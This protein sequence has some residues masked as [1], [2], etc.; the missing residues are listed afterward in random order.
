[1][2]RLLWKW[3]FP[4]CN[5]PITTPHAPFYPLF[6]L[7]V[8]TFYPFDFNLPF[9]FHL[10]SFFFRA[11][12]SF[13]YSP[14]YIF[15]QNDSRWSY[16][17][18]GGGGGNIYTPDYD[19]SHFNES[20]HEHLLKKSSLCLATGLPN[21]IGVMRFPDSSRYEGEFMQ[22]RVSSSC[23]KSKHDWW[24]SSI[25][26]DLGI[27]Q[28]LRKK[29]KMLFSWKFTELHIVMHAGG[30]WSPLYLPFLVSGHWSHI[31][32]NTKR[33]CRRLSVWPDFSFRFPL[34]TCMFTKKQGSI[35]WSK[36]IFI[37]PSP[38]PKMIFFPLSDTTFFKLPLWPFCLNSPYFA[39]ILP[40]SFTFLF[41]YPFLL[42]F[43]LSSFFFCIFP[44]FLF[45]FSYFSPQVTS[46]DI[47]PE[48]KRYFQH[49]DPCQEVYILY[50]IGTHPFLWNSWSCVRHTLTHTLLPGLVW[51]GMTTSKCWSDRYPP[52]VP[53]FMWGAGS[54]PGTS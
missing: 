19:R 54:G 8:S 30:Q 4:S 20:T 44:L 50:S 41:S 35:F 16:I 32:R 22:V 14:L 37:L 40:F 42:F 5:V 9:I 29:G 26:I 24:R 34:Y 39:F 53:L 49:I 18:P 31:P 38:F 36:T 6:F 52:P 46:A 11:F 27:F 51:E 45:P 43:P 17:H 25:Y 47:P 12:F 7:V 28:D 48:G 15:S 23:R 1:M 21:G 2:F 33:H 3:C 13:S 10:S